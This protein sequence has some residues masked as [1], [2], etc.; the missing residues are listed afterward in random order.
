MELKAP[1]YISSVTQESAD[2]FLFEPIGEGGVNGQEFADEI[3][4]L[5]QFGVKN[6]NIHINT[7]GGEV[8]EGQAIFS[9]MVNSKAHITTI[10]EG[11]VASMGAVI[12]LGGD[13]IKMTE[14]ARLMFHGPRIP[15]GADPDANQQ[16]AIDALTGS[17]EVILKSRTGKGKTEIAAML[18]GDDVW[19]TPAEALAGKFVDEIVTIKHLKE[20]KRQPKSD[21]AATLATII[22]KQEE[23]K[24]EPMKNLCAYLEI[25]ESST[26]AA[27]IE[28]VK[29]IAGDLKTANESLVTATAEA[30]K[31]DE[32]ITA[33]ED[34]NGI[35]GCKSYFRGGAFKGDC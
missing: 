31:K 32:K 18:A 33:L 12:L 14:F 21:I 35:P 27:V 13:T 19:L 23:P 25:N 20:S 10:A 28:A 5:D 6:I 17:L 34:L 3:Q 29:K 4:L 16:A 24:S 9:A 8:V 1:K 22:N 30:T 2:I 11:T 15:N 7:G 26:E